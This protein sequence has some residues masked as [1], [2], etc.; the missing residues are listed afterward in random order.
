MDTAPNQTLYVSNLQEKIKKR[1]LKQLLYALFGQFGKIVDI[2]AMRTDKLRGQAWIVYADI[3][4]ATAAL[5]GMQDFPFFDKPLRVSFAK[6]ASHA[7]APKKGGKGAKGK[8]PKAPAAVAAGGDAAAKAKQPADAAAAGGRQKAAAV[9]VG[10]PNAKLFVENLPAATTAA[11]L[12]ML[13]QQFPG[14]KEVTT[15]PAKPGIAFIEFETEMQATV[16]MT[17]LQGFKV[18]P[19][20]SMTITYSK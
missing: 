2:V 19:Q 8:P 12:E 17:G 4:A 20:N 1:E 16:A 7:V 9:D 6:S 13:F 15:V 10:E 18:T 11:M 3:T 14:C 5:R